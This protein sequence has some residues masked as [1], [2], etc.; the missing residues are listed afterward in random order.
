MRRIEYKLIKNV[1]RQG[2]EAFSEGS[3]WLIDGC[4][5]PCCRPYNYMIKK[6]LNVAITNLCSFLG[7]DLHAHFQ[8][9][10]LGPFTRAYIYIYILKNQIKVS[11]TIFYYYYFLFLFFFWFS[12]IRILI[13]FFI[14]RHKFNIKLL[15]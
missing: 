11:F 6:G 4:F 1:K 3:G 5:R 9:H 10:P 13:I 7:R 15:S 2:A 8:L 12:N 14:T